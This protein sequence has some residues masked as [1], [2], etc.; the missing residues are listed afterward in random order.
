MD[1]LPRVVQ[2]DLRV[3]QRVDDAVEL[4]RAGRRKQPVEHPAERHESDAILVTQIPRRERCSSSHRIVQRA[5]PLRARF[6]ERVDDE[7]HIRV[8]FRMLLVDPKLSPSRGRAPVD[9]PDTIAG[10][11]RAKICELDPLGLLPRDV[12][13]AEDLGL[14][15]T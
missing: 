11:E 3:E 10:D 1:V 4:R 2:N 9:V 6:G 12:I 8:A 5:A 14:S 7:D 13:A 15:R